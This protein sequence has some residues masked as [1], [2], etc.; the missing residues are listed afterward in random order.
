MAPYH[1]EK[2]SPM[3]WMHS[4]GSMHFNALKWIHVCTGTLRAKTHIQRVG[5]SPK[6]TVMSACCS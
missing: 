1:L 5:K 6:R 2:Q 4:N 3:K